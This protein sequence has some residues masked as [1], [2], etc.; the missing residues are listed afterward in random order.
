MAILPIRNKLNGGG[1]MEFPFRLRVE[2]KQ[3]ISADIEFGITPSG[4]AWANQFGG[5]GNRWLVAAALCERTPQTVKE[6][7]KSSMVKD[8][9]DIKAALVWLFRQQFVRTAD[10]GDEY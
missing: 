6:L 1:M 7:A 4:K 5:G 10:A 8:A 3:R 9:N 2:R